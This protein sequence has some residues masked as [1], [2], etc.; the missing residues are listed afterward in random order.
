MAQGENAS[1]PYVCRAARSYSAEGYGSLSKSD[2]FD[3]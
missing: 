2:Q 3:G 1:S